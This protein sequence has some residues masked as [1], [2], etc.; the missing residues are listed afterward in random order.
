MKNLF[1]KKNIIN[2][3]VFDFYFKKLTKNN[4][5]LINIYCNSIRNSTHSFDCCGY[6]FIYYSSTNTNG[7]EKISN[8][9]ILTVWKKKK[10]VHSLNKKYFVLN[11]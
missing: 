7:V 3:Q 8:Y 4:L 10:I 9:K 11:N 1:L 6:N 2:F 5:I